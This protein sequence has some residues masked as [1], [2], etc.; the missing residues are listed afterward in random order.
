MSAKSLWR[1]VGQREVKLRLNVF[2]H[3]VSQFTKDRHGVRVSRRLYVDDRTS[4]SC[5]LKRLQ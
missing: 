3:I 1:V 4:S 2:A 5:P